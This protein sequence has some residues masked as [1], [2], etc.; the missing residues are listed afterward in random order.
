MREPLEYPLQVLGSDAPPGVPNPDRDLV[1]GANGGE[2][3][4]I[5]PRAEL[6]GVLDQG[7][8]RNREPVRV[9]LHLRLVHHAQAPLAWN[10]APA[11]QRLYQDRLHLDL[12]LAQEVGVVR[13]GQ[14]QQAIRE[15]A[16]PHQLVH[17]D[18][19]V[20]VEACGG[21]AG[22][23]LD[24]AQRDRDR[25]PKL[26][27][28]VL[29]EL[30]LPVGKPLVRLGDPLQVFQGRQPAARVPHHREEHGGHQGH[31]GQLVRRLGAG[32]EVGVDGYGRQPDDDGEDGEGRAA[33]PD[34]YAVED[35]KADPDEVE[36]DRLP[37]PED[38]HRDQVQHREDAP[39][40][41]EPDPA[42]EQPAKP[43]RRR[44]HGIPHPGWW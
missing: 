29:D 42:G 8:D 4:D 6:H 21:R 24:V 33:P 43:V 31:L 39:A 13:R 35:G 12:D 10:R 25:R 18:L 14:H 26:V 19:R 5:A 44:R 41:V 36:G 7:V 23:Q 11:P 28:G 40:D 20:F 37:V 1:C 15:P 32:P 27:R 16:Q 30:A 22:D 34:P 38:E 3:D 2:L 9:R 17:R